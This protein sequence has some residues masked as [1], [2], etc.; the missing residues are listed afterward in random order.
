[1]FVFLKFEVLL[2][3]VEFELKLNKRFLNLLFFLFSRRK[4]FS[5][6]IRNFVF[7]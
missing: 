4:V 1:M 7:N 2:L 5:S 3:N 6:L